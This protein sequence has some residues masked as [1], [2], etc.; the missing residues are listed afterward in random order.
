MGS[1]DPYLSA[2]DAD[3]C[4]FLFSYFDGTSHYSK[5]RAKMEE[6]VGLKN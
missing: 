1:T 3:V 2:F 6:N 5:V 4:H